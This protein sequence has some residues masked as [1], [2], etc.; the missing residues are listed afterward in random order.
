MTRI[1]LFPLKLIL[2]PY[3]K[4][5]LHIFEPRYK[6]MVSESLKMDKPFGIVFNKGDR[7][8][9]IGCCVKITDIF[10]KYPNGEYD[11]MVKGENLFNIIKTNKE[12]DL[13]I[14]K[15]NYITPPKLVKTKKLKTLQDTYLKILI[16]FGN[17]LIFEKH[18][19]LS[20]SYEFI[21]QIQLPLRVK[22]KIL[23]IPDEID[24]LNLIQDIFDNI[25]NEASKKVETSKDS[26]AKA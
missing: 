15:V 2:L 13:I 25:L 26:F 10:K 20:I 17:D 21:K 5:P 14:G 6:K 1:T 22:E 11:L 24:R 9:N 4:L 18:M 16:R 12:E 23:E 7:I 19:N 8:H 3:E